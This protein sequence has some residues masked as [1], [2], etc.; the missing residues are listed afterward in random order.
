MALQMLWLGALFITSGTIVSAAY[1]AAGGW[2]S[3][4]L[5]REPRWQRRL[6]RLSGSILL[7]LGLRLLIPQRGV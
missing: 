5:R 7:A 2:V 3:D 1:A 4:R 6:D